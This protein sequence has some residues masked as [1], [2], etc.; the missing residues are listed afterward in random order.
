MSI[1]QMMT[2]RSARGKKL[3]DLLKRE[4]NLPE[5]L[6]WFEVR[7]GVDEIVSVQCR[8]LVQEPDDERA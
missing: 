3:C 2:E 5:N 6:Q 4:L 1:K 7:F 8:F